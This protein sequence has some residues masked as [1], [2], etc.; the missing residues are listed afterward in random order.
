[1]N[2]TVP[3]AP[4]F[5]RIIVS[6]FLVCKTMLVV[7]TYKLFRM[8][9]SLKRRDKF[10]FFQLGGKPLVI[11]LC[12]SNKHWKEKFIQFKCSGGLGVNMEWRVA[13]DGS[14]KVTG[15]AKVKPAIFAQ[16]R[17]HSFFEN[18]VKDT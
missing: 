7:P 1:M 8:F 15:V 10:H 14:S 5:R 17:E 18:L 12:R 3:L 16:V 9:Y 13:S 11:D 4:N 2:C 6:F